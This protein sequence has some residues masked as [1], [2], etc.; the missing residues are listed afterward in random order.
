MHS[1]GTRSLA[2]EVLFRS[3][4]SGLAG[5]SKLGKRGIQ[6]DDK[7]SASLRK[8]AEGSWFKRPRI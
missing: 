5:L 8:L 6:M 4:L 1:H 3:T 2:D 7:R